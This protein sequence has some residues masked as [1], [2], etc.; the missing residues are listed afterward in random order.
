MFEVPTVPIV[1]PE[2]GIRFD[3]LLFRTPTI[4]DVP[5]VAPAF[6][7]PDIGGRANMPAFDEEAVRSSLPILEKNMGEGTFLAL[8]VADPE[9]GEVYGGGNLHRIDR[10]L[11]QG[12]IGYWLFPEARG[13][14]IATRTARFLADFGFAI[15]LERI[16]ARV[17]YGN[18]E[19]ERVLERAGFTKEGVLRSLPRRAGGRDDM[20]LYSL[21]LGE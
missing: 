10:E 13:R 18:P 7:D 16:E 15:G 4:D 3:G 14:G 20:I 21:L 8:L 12:E 5:L 6:Q 2:K 9:S 19:S 1:F 11:G 17:F